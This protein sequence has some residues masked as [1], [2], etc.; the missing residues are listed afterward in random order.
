MSGKLFGAVVAD[1]PVPNIAEHTATLVGNKIYVFGGYDLADEEIVGGCTNKFRVVDYRRNVCELFD[2]PLPTARRRHAACL[3]NDKLFV[4]GGTT[5]SDQ[6]AWY[7][8]LVLQE[9]TSRV[10]G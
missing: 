4:F 5:G 6:Q 1:S 8:D 3:A 9:W 10:N 7:F 2:G